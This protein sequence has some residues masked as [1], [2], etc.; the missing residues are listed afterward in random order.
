[1]RQSRAM[2]GPRG[3][4]TPSR[5]VKSVGGR[6]YGPGVSQFARGTGAQ[7]SDRS[8]PPVPEV[9]C[10]FLGRLL[11]DPDDAQYP[12]PPIAPTGLSEL[13]EVLDGGIRGG[14]MALI[15]GVTGA[16]A[17][18]LALTIA[19]TAATKRHMRTL[20]IAPDMSDTE[21]YYRIVAAEAR[22]SVS[23]V[24]RGI[25]HL[26]EADAE[27]VADRRQQ[28]QM[29]PIW[30]L[31]GVSWQKSLDVQLDV[32]TYG[33]PSREDPWGARLVVIDGTATFEPDVRRAMLELRRF[34][35]ERQLA[36]VVTTRAL[37]PRDRAAQPP[38]LEDLVEYESSVD[39]FD[40]VLLLHR[41]DMQNLHSIRPGEV[42]I[43]IAKN[44]YGAIRTVTVLCQGHYARMVDLV[45]GV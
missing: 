14:Q 21:L 15:G 42:D 7:P 20:F 33:T 26:S 19:R 34:A 6:S 37:I 11:K 4:S 3:R 18:M 30:L 2:G 32:M 25:G 29:L 40:S 45:P 41:D 10:N 22:V 8:Y 43:N 38:R 31:G 39:L 16:G 9:M 35:L 13:D 24:R 12:L 27:R 1:M 17:S 36:V 44:R 5:P 23:K 28:L